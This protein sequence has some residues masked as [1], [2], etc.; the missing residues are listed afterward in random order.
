MDTSFEFW[1]N[2]SEVR[3]A[4]VD[5]N[6]TLLAFL[7]ARGLTGTKESCA[8]GECGA[9]AVV[10]LVA[11]ANGR[12][13]FQAINSCLVLLPE[14]AGSEVWTVEGVRRNGALHPV[15]QAMVEH[16]GSQCGYCTPGFVMSLFAFYYSE[17]R[18]QPVAALA[19][20]LCRCTGYRPI[21]DAAASLPAAAAGSDAFSERLLRPAPVPAPLC[22]RT[23][24]S[25]FDRPTTLQAALALRD[26]F[27][28]A[29][30]LQGG[31]DLAVEVNQTGAHHEHVIALG[32]VT[33]L[34]TIAAS[35]S[36]IR[37]GAGVTWAQLERELG[38]RLPL[39]AQ[40]IPL[41]GS[42]LIRARATLGG[43]LATASP[44]GDAA[45][46]LLALDA[47]V[48]IASLDGRRSVPLR[49]FFT[50]YRRT[51][52]ESDELVAAVRVPLAPPTLARFYKV[53]KRELDDISSVSAAIAVWLEGGRVKQARLAFGGV[54]AT[55]VRAFA[56]EQA[57]VGKPLDDASLQTCQ[58]A[59]AGSFT[60]IDDVRAS[61]A[62]R[63]AMLT[64][65]LAKFWAEVP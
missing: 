59:V 42:P 15:Q 46:A 3:V 2:G 38:D 16:G 1:L 11:A 53:S 50:G 26:E 36:E 27:P 45:P 43:N 12:S 57:L 64:S 18:P 41:F 21:R 33:E 51:A 61:A 63:R 13:A 17:P 65:L 44:V 14:V 31:T 35:G 30:L 58:R 40:V 23:Q 9:C 62:Y 48:E 54:A 37:I 10:V 28:S 39:L 4:D 56:A 20:N 24:L 29:T 60:P 47:E 22:Y 8:E 34:R 32:G 5:P 52:L 49:E 19:G 7:R 25:R 55:P 6:T